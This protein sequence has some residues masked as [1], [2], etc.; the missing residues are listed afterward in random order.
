MLL[1]LAWRDRVCRGFWQNVLDW[2][3]SRF[4]YRLSLN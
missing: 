1:L 4:H 2:R 3:C